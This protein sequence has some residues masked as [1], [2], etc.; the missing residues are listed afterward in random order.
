MSITPSGTTIH[1]HRSSHQYGRGFTLIEVLVTMVV[2]SIGLLGLAE[3]Q[4]SGLRANMSSEARSKATLLV[5]D[6]I[7]RMR[8]NPLGVTIG[9]YHGIAASKTICEGARPVPF[10]SSTSDNSK[11]VPPCP[12][13]AAMAAFDAWVWA[14]GMAS[15]D[16]RKS[17]VV[18]RLP[19]GIANVTCNDNNPDDDFPC[20]PGS[21][22]TIAVSWNEL[23][24]TG[25]ATTLQTISL[26]V[27]P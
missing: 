26:T 14:C 23:S 5:S 17:G 2:V 22:N 21:L 16:V 4:I 27:V 12:T 8:A 1:E 24:P 25:G 10:C 20:T 6:I 19:N 18:N 13:A 3:L 7:E 9:A 15:P 11:V